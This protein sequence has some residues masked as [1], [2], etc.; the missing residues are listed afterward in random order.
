MQSERRFPRRFR[1]E[2]LDHAPARQ[3]ADPQCRI[4]RNRSG[5]NHGDRQRIPRPELQDGS[6]AEL[7]FHLNHCLHD[8]LR[9]LGDGHA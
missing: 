8:E 5:R 1:P 9:A 6:L 2:N 7:L 4:D 3:P